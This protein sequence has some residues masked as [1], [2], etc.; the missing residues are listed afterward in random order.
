[1]AGFN[2][3]PRTWVAGE[4]VGADELNDEVRDPLTGI[5]GIWDDYTPVLTSTGTAPNIGTDGSALGYYLQIGKTILVRA[6]ITLGTVGNGMVV[7]TG[8]YHVSVP[9]PFRN[10]IGTQLLLRINDATGNIYAGESFGASTGGTTFAIG[11]I[12]STGLAAVTSTSPF[13][14]AAG[15][16]IDLLT[17][18]YEAA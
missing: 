2:Y 8:T 4:V 13:T 9:F 15:D 17:G 1:M 3:T 12:A 7:G 10:A 6:R 14:F 5:Q 16:S 18:I 11:L